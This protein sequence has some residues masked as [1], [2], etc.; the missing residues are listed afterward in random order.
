MSTASLSSLLLYQKYFKANKAKPVE[1][2]GDTTV[3]RTKKLIFLLGEGRRKELHSTLDISL[4][5]CFLPREAVDARSL[6][7]FKA[8]LDEALRSLI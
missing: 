1:V 4:V 7:G 6:E 5:T 3:K 2:Q 8:R